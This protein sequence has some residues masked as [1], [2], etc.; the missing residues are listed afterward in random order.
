LSLKTEDASV[1]NFNVSFTT[2]L[3]LDFFWLLTIARDAPLAKAS[4]TN[5]LP[6]LFSPLIAKKILYLLISLELI[7]AL[8]IFNFN[9]F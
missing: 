4:L 8:L 7:D 5:K 1:K 2:I 6:S 3:F 9:S